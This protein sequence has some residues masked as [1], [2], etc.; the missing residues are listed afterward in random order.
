MEIEDGNCSQGEEPKSARGSIETQQNIKESRESI[1]SQNETNDENE[2][3][4]SLEL[5]QEQD[6]Q[7][8]QQNQEEM[9]GEENGETFIEFDEEMEQE[10]D[11]DGIREVYNGVYMI[12]GVYYIIDEN[13]EVNED[14]DIDDEEEGETLIPLEFDDEKETVTSVA[15]S[16]LVQYEYQKEMEKQQKKFEEVESRATEEHIKSIIAIQTKIRCRKARKL[17]E[18]LGMKERKN[19]VKELI[20]SEH[21]YVDNLTI[22][23]KYYLD[24]LLAEKDDEIVRI[25]SKNL[26][27]IIKYNTTLLVQLDA[28]LKKSVYGAQIAEIFNK[29][30]AFL[31]SYTSYV[32]QYDQ[33][34]DRVLMLSQKNIAIM[35]LLKKLSMQPEVKNLNI[36][37]YLIL[38]IQRVPRYELF[39][40]GVLKQLPKT[41]KDFKGLQDVM[42]KIKE[43]GDYLNTKRKEFEN[44][45]LLKKFK[46]Q[47]EIKKFDLTDNETR[48]LE[49]YGVIKTVEHGPIILFLLS[50][51]LLIHKAK[52][53]IKDVDAYIDKGKVK[54]KY[55]IPTSGLGLYDNGPN[56]FLIV[57]PKLTFTFETT[58][59]E[60]KDD[61]MMSFDETFAKKQT[62]A[63][64]RINTARESQTIVS[65]K[66]D[67]IFFDGF[68]TMRLNTFVECN[69]KNKTVV[70]FH[71]S[72]RVNENQSMAS[73]QSLS[74]SHTL[75]KLNQSF[76]RVFGT[77]IDYDEEAERYCRVDKDYF[78]VYVNIQDSL[79]KDKWLMRVLLN[80]FSVEA[81]LAI[82]SEGSFQMKMYGKILTIS[83]QTA[84]DKW[85]WINVF[86]DAF[87][88]TARDKL[89]DLKIIS[90]HEDVTNCFPCPIP[91]L[92]EK[93]N[94]SHYID[95]I[96][97]IPTNSCCIDCRSPN[98]VSADMT[99]GVFLCRDCANIHKN[100]MKSEIVPIRNLYM[101][102]NF[103]DINIFMKRGNSVTEHLIMKHLPKEVYYHDPESL[104]HSVSLRQEFVPIKYRTVPKYNPK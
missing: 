77:K 57:S 62:S 1:N 51:F 42:I 15:R 69:K 104:Q 24:K 3:V 13:P 93:G 31:K 103:K 84:K 55:I 86:R 16:L 10:E 50:D 67:Y 52:N 100:Q 99:Y 45:Q 72:L 47:L 97:N 38:P 68:L 36:F 56:S 19:L 78:Y 63:A 92:T 37:S 2:I 87:Y 58:N 22:L 8:N 6:N 96:L 101:K 61:W 4:E 54:I 82:N 83:A 81:V 73:T 49:K 94:F 53:D 75:P 12:D 23:Q 33:T 27:M 9:I 14:E 7:I 32:N 91:N 64:S 88:T 80:S 60:E 98:I 90:Q 74:S 102:S 29:F 71:P 25:C 40:R 70:E 30:A 59:E 20:D 79:E 43:I 85:K 39:I 95:T 11:E 48:S 76:R 65:T 35:N 34:N 41:H 44:K 46:Y 21:K 18:V 28:M 5:S 17:P 66:N 26:E 89:I